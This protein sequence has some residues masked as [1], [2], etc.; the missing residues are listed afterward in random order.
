MKITSPYPSQ[1]RADWAP[2]GFL[3][4]FT[5]TAVTWVPVSTLSTLCRNDTGSCMPHRESNLV[6]SR[7]AETK[8][9]HGFLQKSLLC[10]GKRSPW[11]QSR[12]LQELGIWREEAKKG[13]QQT[14]ETGPNTWLLFNLIHF[15]FMHVNKMSVGLGTFTKSDSWHLIN[16]FWPC[17]RNWRY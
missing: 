3:H 8:I 7:Q 16:A 2:W 1:P 15:S 11:L 6:S 13:P 10:Q 12:G 4:S 14:P 5:V 9:C 17:R